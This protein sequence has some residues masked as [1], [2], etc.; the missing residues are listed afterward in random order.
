M[1]ILPDYYDALGQQ[2]FLY[3]P[4]SRPVRAS[5][6]LFELS[7]I[8]ACGPFL[9]C[10]TVVADWDL[11]VL[12]RTKPNSN[13]RSVAIYLVYHIDLCITFNEVFLIDTDVVD[14]EILPFRI[15]AQ[16]PKT[17]LEIAP[18]PERLTINVYLAIVFPIT[19][20]IRYGCVRGYL[21]Q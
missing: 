5:R 6:Y 20:T 12:A 18:N 3:D 13:Q 11:S 8:T 21:A 16:G 7:R 15:P 19:P 4:Q 14:P 10:R 2:E 9:Q 1:V 17:I